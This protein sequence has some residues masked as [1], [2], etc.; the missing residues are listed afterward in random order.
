MLPQPLDILIAF[1]SIS[2]APDL[3]VTEKR[4]ASAV[5]DHFNQ[6]TT[7]CDPSLDTLAVLLGIYRRTVIRAI[8]NLVG[9]KYFRRVRHGGNFHRNF[10][11]PLWPRFRGGKLNGKVGGTST[12]NDFVKRN[13]HVGGDGPSTLLVVRM[14]PKLVL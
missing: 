14:S 12:A 9:L 10:Y 7:Q 8:N 11:E 3:S 5:I 1:K 6:K 4:V 2:L 13:C